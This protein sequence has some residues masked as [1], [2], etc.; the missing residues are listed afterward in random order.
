LAHHLAHAIMTWP[1]P[2]RTGWTWIR[3]TC[4][5]PCGRFVIY[6]PDSPAAVSAEAR[7]LAVAYGIS[8]LVESWFIGGGTYQVAATAGIPR[9]FSPK[10]GKW[11]SSMLSRCATVGD[12]ST[13]AEPELSVVNYQNGDP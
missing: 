3:A 2:P 13:K 11:A 4:T 5:K 7:R 10:A 1:A 8:V 6:W 12:S 9:R